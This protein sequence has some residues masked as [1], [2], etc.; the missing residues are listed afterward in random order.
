[1]VF[2]L[3][4]TKR[5]KSSRKERERERSES[6]GKL[7]TGHSNRKLSLLVHSGYVNIISGTAECD[8]LVALN[9]IHAITV[10]TSRKLVTMK[11]LKLV[12]PLI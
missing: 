8:S 9:S 3:Y 1:M 11:R 12:M 7:K 5:T 4:R 10:I 2:L 6:C